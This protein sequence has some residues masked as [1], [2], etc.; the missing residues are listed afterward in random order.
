MRFFKQDLE[1]CGKSM[2]WIMREYRREDGKS[3]ERFGEFYAEK[4]HS[5]V[6]YFENSKFIAK[7][8]NKEIN[9]S[10]IE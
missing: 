10:L 8:I 6:G 7:L 4:D 1:N 3:G 9:H 2:I 5:Y